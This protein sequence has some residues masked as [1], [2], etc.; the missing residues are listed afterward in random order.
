MTRHKYV[1]SFIG[2]SL[3]SLVLGVSFHYVLSPVLMI[4]SLLSGLAAV[5]VLIAWFAVDVRHAS[6]RG[7]GKTKAGEKS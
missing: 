5:A 4:G 3:I 7:K 6:G 2:L 1:L